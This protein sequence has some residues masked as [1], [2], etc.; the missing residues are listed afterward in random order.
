MFEEI[1]HDVQKVV[2]DRESSLRYYNT[3]QIPPEGFYRLKAADPMP[4]HYIQ[5]LEEHAADRAAVDI[6]ALARASAK[7]SM[8]DNNLPS[9]L[10][11]MSNFA[12]EQ[13]ASDMEVSPTAIDAQPANPDEASDLDI[14]VIDQEESRE[15]TAEALQ[16]L[17]PFMI[18]IGRNTLRK[19][20][21]IVSPNRLLTLDEKSRPIHELWDPMTHEFE[22]FQ[23]VLA[24]CD[25]LAPST[26]A[27]DSNHKNSLLDLCQKLHGE[28]QALK[29]QIID[30]AE[31]EPMYSSDLDKFFD[32]ET[33]AKILRYRSMVMQ[34]LKT[35]V[36]ILRESEFDFDNAE[37]KV[38]DHPTWSDK[39]EYFEWRADT[40]LS[41]MLNEY[42]L[43]FSLK[44]FDTY[45]PQFFRLPSG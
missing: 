17:L 26:V 5:S 19:L 4:A 42:L 29:Q 20:L 21:C 35:A 41:H 32:K 25:K 10:Q 31:P 33:M 13:V 28:Q 40:S 18:D 44:I 43:I 7:Q 38:T 14:P 22:R 34:P 1:R 9:S 16:N 30:S 11:I 36:E 12:V 23:A 39:M 45:V 24:D 27:A 8:W 3:Y 15:D 2:R 37:H 6:V